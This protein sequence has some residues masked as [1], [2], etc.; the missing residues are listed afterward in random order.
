MRTLFILLPGISVSA[1]FAFEGQLELLKKYGSIYKIEYNPKR[2]KEK[3]L[4]DELHKVMSL[5]DYDNIFFIGIS[6]GAMCSLRFFMQGKS[7]YMKKITGV[8]LLGP[9]LSANDYNDR[10]LWKLLPI[11][12]LQ[13]TFTHKVI[14]KVMQY[15]FVG[16]PSSPQKRKARE[17]VLAVSNR[18]YVERIQYVLEKKDLEHINNLPNTPVLFIWWKKDFVSESKRREIE[19]M[20]DIVKSKS[21]T[22]QHG[23]LWRKRE[24]VNMYFKEFLDDH[25]R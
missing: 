16:D 11:H 17:S 13:S 8:I 19:G 20:F 9:V 4:F 2:F 22:G 3:D 23:W 24:I 15:I 7:A 5:E 18:A 1:E 21:I 12:L 25:A 10:L 6:F 14:A